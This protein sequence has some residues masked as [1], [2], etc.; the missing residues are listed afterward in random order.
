M[1]LGA[2]AAWGIVLPENFNFP[3]RQRSWA[4]FWKSWHSS[5]TGWLWQYIFNPIFLFF[6]RRGISKTIATLLCATCTFAGMALFNGLQ[7]G[8]FISAGIFAFFYFAAVLLNSKKNVLNSIF[9]FLIFSLSLIF[10]RNPQP[11]K[12]SFITGQ[13]FNFT[14][15]LPIDWQAGFFAPLASGGSQHDYFNLTVTLTLTLLFFASEKKTYRLFAREKINYA[16]WFITI[17]L[18][19]LWGVFENGE[20]FIYMQF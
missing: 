8:F 11:Q 1:A 16:A 9:I 12:Y 4:D 10:F 5:L 15:F 7:S 3:F 19:L 13:I 18:L 20:R 17:I 6:N 14:N 2:A